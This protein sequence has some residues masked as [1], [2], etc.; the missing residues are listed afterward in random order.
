MVIFSRKH[1]GSTHHAFIVN[2]HTLQPFSGIM[3]N[4]LFFDTIMLNVLCK[5]LANVHLYI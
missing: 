5:A 2:P 3:L 4:V 1:Y